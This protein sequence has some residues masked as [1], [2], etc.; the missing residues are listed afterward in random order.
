MEEQKKVLALHDLAAMGRAA[1]VPVMAALSGLGHQCVP[2]P[3]AVFSTHTGIPQFRTVDLTGWMAQTL[4]H[5]A[6]L[7]LRFDGVLS[8][9]LSSPEQVDVVQRGAAQRTPEGIFLVDPVMGDGGKIYKT[10]TPPLVARMGELCRAADVITPN[11]TEAAVL[12][13]RAPDETPSGLEEAAA[14]AQTLARIYDAR[15]ALTGLSDG[16]DLVVLCCENGQV[17]TAR[18]RRIGAYYPGTGDL[19]AAVLLGGLLR[20]Q[21]LCAAA[22]AAADFV[23]ACIAATQAR[24]SDPCWGV[25][26]ETQIWRLIPHA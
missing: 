1:L 4:D 10:Y 14:W 2:V 19:F 22:Q 12:T 21:E 18:N 9:F 17:Q 11:L 3:T 16:E 6:A 15:V 7:G 8:G 26:V 20:G 13:G 23:G 24:G 5:F 25:A